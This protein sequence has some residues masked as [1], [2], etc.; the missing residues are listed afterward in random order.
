MPCSSKSPR[1]KKPK[2]GLCKLT[3]QHGSYVNSHIIPAALTRLPTN[4]EKI[5]EAGIGL[6]TIRRPGSWYDNRL[7]IRTGEDILEAIDTIAIE[8]LREHK[9]IWS[10]GVAETHLSTTDLLP[11]S[12]N[13]GIREILIPRAKELQCFFLSLLWR[14]AASERPEF[15]L[16]TLSAE[17]LE[18]LRQ[19]IERQEPGPFSDFP[20]QLFQI[21]SRGIE[22]NRTPLLERKLIELESGVRREVDYV[23]FYFDGL[24]AHAH[25]SH[26]DSFDERYLNT[27]LRSDADTIVFVQEFKT[28][29]AASDIKLM[30]TA[31]NNESRTPDFPI[32]AIAA[33]V[34]DAWRT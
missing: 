9:L 22:H 16:I 10:S 14:S 23:R 29:R 4:G 6:R 27:C 33:A 31:V 5:V 24:V 21:I 12:E 15:S 25:I 32:S 2:T 1:Q 11:V 7:V 19:R 13:N 30:V 8:I 20:V 18:N 3:G 34:R 17:T 28:S 26:K